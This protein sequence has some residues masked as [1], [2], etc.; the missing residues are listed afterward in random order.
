M[1]VMSEQKLVTVE[2][3]FKS[4]EET[5]QLAD[6]IKEAVAMIV[7]REALEDFRVHVMPLT[8]PRHLRGV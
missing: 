1:R 4:A 7:G 2:M 3:R 6:R 8:P 5:R